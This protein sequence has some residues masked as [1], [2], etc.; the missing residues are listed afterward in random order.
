M[1]RLTLFF[2]ILFAA[3]GRLATGSAQTGAVRM[4]APDIYF[5]EGDHR[6]GH[7][8]NG[9]I[10]FDDHVMVIDGQPLPK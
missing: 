3:M 2:P 8:N 6:L 5:H 4:S 1:T 7:C 9:W 10:L